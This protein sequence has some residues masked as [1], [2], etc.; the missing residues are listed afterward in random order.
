MQ[1]FRFKSRLSFSKSN[2]DSL[3]ASYKVFRG[4]P[5]SCK[6]LKF[7]LTVGS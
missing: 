5:A 4:P 6:L 7:L 3:D 2:N 1:N